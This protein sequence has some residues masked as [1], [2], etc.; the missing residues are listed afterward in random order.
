MDKGREIFTSKSYET[1]KDSL[2]SNLLGNPFMPTSN[3]SIQQT[4][5]LLAEES[6]RAGA[7]LPNN[8]TTQP[9]SQQQK[10]QPGK[11]VS[12]CSFL[13]VA[14]WRA[15]FPIC[16]TPTQLTPQGYYGIYIHYAFLPSLTF[17]VDLTFFFSFLK[18]L[19]IITYW[20]LET[21]LPD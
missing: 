4:C 2:G 9:S 8:T 1:S 20:E 11:K 18:Q 10:P 5:L 15:V 19:K 6:V 21:T 3:Q 7:L 12:L 14:L 16:I 17:R 13:H